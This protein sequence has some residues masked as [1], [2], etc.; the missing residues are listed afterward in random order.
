MIRGLD[1]NIWSG[2]MFWKRFLAFVI[3]ILPAAG[4]A[5]QAQTRYQNVVTQAQQSVAAY[6]A[7]NERLDKT[8]LFQR[9]DQTL[10]FAPNDARGIQKVAIKRTATDQEKRDILEYRSNNVP[11]KK[12][13][14]EEIGQ[15]HPLFVKVLATWFAEIDKHTLRLINDE[16]TLG[17]ANQNVVK[18]IPQRIR[19]WA[20]ADYQIWQELQSA[21]QYEPHNR[22]AAAT[23]LQRW[24]Y[25]QQL[26][27]QN[28]RMINAIN[29]PS[30]TNC[31]FIGNTVNCIGH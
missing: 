26:L 23:A 13:I 7:C 31:R 28:Q 22:T 18:L 21:D 17:E 9:L 6:D 24:S 30:I 19:Q 29:G 12:A 25:Q 14:L 10:I 2:A 15:A 8:D 11:C 20:A 1:A 16:I 4:C 5:T 3:L 27:N